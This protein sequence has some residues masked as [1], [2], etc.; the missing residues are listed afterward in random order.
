MK[1]LKAVEY[2]SSKMPSKYK[3]KPVRDQ[4]EYQPH[5]AVS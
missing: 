1:F 4:T 5:K 3:Q 2:S